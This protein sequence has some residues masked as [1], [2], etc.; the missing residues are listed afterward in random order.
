MVSA[1]T[2]VAPHADSN[3]NRW[4]L[5]A[6]LDNDDGISVN[7]IAKII[8]FTNGKTA[9]SERG[10]MYFR[11]A[12]GQLWALE[13]SETDIFMIIVKIVLTLAI[14]AMALIILRTWVKRRV[15]KR[16]PKY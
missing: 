2:Q 3:G 5:Y 12:R 4:Y 1:P 11:D 9:V 16:P 8:D 6:I 14:I 13:V 7:E 10:I 15:E